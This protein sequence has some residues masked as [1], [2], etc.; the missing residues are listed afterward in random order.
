MSTNVSRAPF[1]SYLGDIDRTPLLSATEERQQLN[2]WTDPKTGKRWRSVWLR[3]GPGPVDCGKCAN[4]SG[5]LT[6]YERLAEPQ[7]DSVRTVGVRP[8]PLWPW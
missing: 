8:Q 6:G 1:S 5:E 2:D 7:G 4:V 3:H